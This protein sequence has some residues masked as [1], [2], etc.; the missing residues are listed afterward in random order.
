MFGATIWTLVAGNINGSSG[1][2]S[3]SFTSP[4]DVKYDP[5]GNMYV[6]DRDN[7]CIQ[8]FSGGGMTSVTIAGITRVIG[9]NATTFNVPWSVSL[10]SQLNFYVADSGNHR[11]QKFL[12]Y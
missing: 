7:H 5:M 10:D 9:I 6:A 11:I 2:T 1:I 12:R 3:T 8:F 4:I